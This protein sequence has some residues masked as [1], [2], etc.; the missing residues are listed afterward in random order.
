MR[1]SFDR[2]KLQKII[3]S[4]YLISGIHS[5][6]YDDKGRGLAWS[7]NQVRSPLCALLRKNPEFEK[8]CIKSDFDACMRCKSTGKGEMY[9]CH[10]GL[11]EFVVPIITEKNLIV[12]YIVSG[13]LTPY[14]LKEESLQQVIDK[15]ASYGVSEPVILEAYF[16]HREISP[17]L[18]EAAFEI[19]QA[20]TAY[21]WMS[22]A[23][24]I[25]EGSLAFQVSDYITN[26]LDGSLGTEQICSH[27]G[28]S[29]TRINRL[30]QEYFG[31]SLQNY[32]RR[33]RVDKSKTLLEDTD[34]QICQIARQVG[35]PDYNYFT[36]VFKS[37]E[38]CTPRD[39]RRSRQKL[40]MN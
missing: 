25:S 8:Q 39:Y 17:K 9:R 13:Q 33:Q 7:Q 31:T 24:S 22:K 4:F 14:G 38:G 6:V 18:M 35:I 12:G 40:I 36:K 37:L 34:L 26:S 20:C 32:I 21:V 1:L 5:V 23:A 19:L 29:K 3:D 16:Q 15:C 2:E 27:L 28:I 10:I 30:A 11:E